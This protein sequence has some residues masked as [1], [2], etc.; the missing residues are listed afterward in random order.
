MLGLMLQSCSGV[1]VK[2]AGLGFLDG[3]GGT[4]V[5]AAFGATG[6]GASAAEEGF[7]SGCLATSAGAGEGEAGTAGFGGDAGARLGGGVGVGVG[8]ETGAGDGLLGKETGGEVVLS[9]FNS[10]AAGGG[11]LLLDVGRGRWS[12]VATGRGASGSLAAR[13]SNRDLSL[14]N[15]VIGGGA[16]ICGGLG[17]VGYSMRNCRSMVPRFS[18]S[19]SVRMPLPL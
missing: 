12:G 2:T 8:V 6:L 5:E 10:A 3:A 1:G 14:L 11:E 19:S 17:Q 4:A 18:S 13:L 16:G 15:M 7:F 9:D